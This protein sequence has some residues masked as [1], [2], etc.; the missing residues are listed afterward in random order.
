MADQSGSNLPKLYRGLLDGYYIE[1]VVDWLPDK[2]VEGDIWTAA[3]K[4][5]PEELGFDSAKVL[6]DNQ[7]HGH[8]ELQILEDVGEG[9]EKSHAQLIK[10]LGKASLTKRLTRNYIEWSGEYRSTTGE[11]VPMMLYRERKKPTASSKVSI[12][13][14]TQDNALDEGSR[15]GVEYCEEGSC[16]PVG[17]EVCVEQSRT[18]EAKDYFQWLKFP[19]EVLCGAA[20]QQE[21]EC[22]GERW[23]LEVD[24]FSEPYWAQELVN[25]PFISSA[26]RSSSVA[27]FDPGIIEMPIA[28]FFSGTVP[29][30]AEAIRNLNEFLNEYFAK[31]ASEG[32]IEINVNA[33]TKFNYVIDLLGPSLSLSLK[34]QGVWEKH[35]LRVMMSQPYPE[36]HPDKFAIYLGL[37]S[38]KYIQWQENTKPPIDKFSDIQGDRL[39]VFVEKI[40][41][42][43]AHRYRAAMWTP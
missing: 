11:K 12:E 29:D 9:A 33:R 18:K 8:L 27:G 7:I 13:R 16:D 14:G 31:S 4:V 26:R 36:H 21:C 10:K 15:H 43:F 2:V 23:L 32:R 19:V 6:G 17:I 1:L 40:I 24:G 41:S 38:A 30:D 25:L 3:H 39:S 34:R 5:T 22:D 42:A 28:S 35:Q 20:S 37:P